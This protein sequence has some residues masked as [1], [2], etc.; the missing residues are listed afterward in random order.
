M[1]MSQGLYFVGCVSGIYG[2]GVTTVSIPW[3]YC[4]G[5][6]QTREQMSRPTSVTTNVYVAS[7][8]GGFTALVGFE[9]G[10]PDP[11][12]DTLSTRPPRRDG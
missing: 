10:S 7:L 4:V 1:Y 8:T 11:E 5:R 6:I 2:F 9:P 3:H 12:F